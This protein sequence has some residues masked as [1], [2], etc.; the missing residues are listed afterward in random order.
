MECLL[1]D[2]PQAFVDA[3][4]GPDITKRARELQALTWILIQCLCPAY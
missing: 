4:D 3:S 2:N 1:G